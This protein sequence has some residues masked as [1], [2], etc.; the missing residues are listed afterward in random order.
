MHV[1]LC[2]CARSK[3]K[4]CSERRTRFSDWTV[5]GIVGELSKS[6]SGSE[7]F[8][9]FRL[10]LRVQKTAS[11]VERRRYNQTLRTTT[12][13]PSIPNSIWAGMAGFKPDNDYFQASEA[14]KQA[15]TGEVL[16][17]CVLSWLKIPWNCIL[18]GYEKPGHAECRN[19]WIFSF[20]MKK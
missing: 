15:P 12:R 4:K 5:A 14:S 20:R 3:G 7:L 16:E 2:E 13:Y 6:K 11:L 17:H 19:L 9:R 8:F 10:S 1:P 18:R